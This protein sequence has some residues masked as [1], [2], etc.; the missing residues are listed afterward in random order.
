VNQLV[1]HLALMKE[2]NLLVLQREIER[3]Q[4]KDYLTV[5]MKRILMKVD[6][7]VYWKV[8]LRETKKI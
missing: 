8:L 2:Q 5:V 7:V 1:L 6:F 4:M 3:L